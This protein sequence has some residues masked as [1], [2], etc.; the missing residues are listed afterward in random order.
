[1]QALAAVLLELPVSVVQGADL[2]GLQPARNAV[3]VKCV[4]E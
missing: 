1:M 3:E 2:S 4:L